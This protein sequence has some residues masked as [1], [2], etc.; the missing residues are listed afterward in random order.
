MVSS[1]TR[2]KAT[3][4]IMCGL[5]SAS[6]LGQAVPALAADGS[7]TI[8]QVAGN[9]GQKYVGYRLFSADV[10]T[11][12]ADDNTLPHTHYGKTYNGMHDDGQAI[13][14]D[15]PDDRSK[16][17]AFLMQSID[18]THATQSYSAWLTA[19][20]LDQT[21]GG[22]SPQNNPQN[23][24]Q[25]ISEMVDSTTA[26]PTADGTSTTPRTTS[27]S[28]FATALAQYLVAQGAVV[29]VASFNTGV[30][31]T[32][33]QGYYLFKTDPTSI[34][35]NEAGEAAMWVPISNVAKTITEKA[36]VPT[37]NKEVQEDATGAW[38]ATADANRAQEVSF[39]VTGTLPTNLAAFSD[40]FYEFEDQL[41]AGMSLANGDTSGVRVTHYR[42]A[43]DTTGTNVTNSFTRSYSGD[44]L[45]VTC[46]NILPIANVTKDSRFVVTYTAHLDNDGIIGGTGNTN[47]VHLNYTNDPITKA[48]GRT[49]D[50]DNTVY[51]YLLQFEKLDK[52]TREPIQGAKFTVRLTT[53]DGSNDTASVNKYLQADGSLGAT[54]YEFTTDASGRFSVPRIDKG[55][56]T[57]NETYAPEPYDKMD[58]PV[59]T[60]IGVTLPTAAKTNIGTVQ[61]SMSWS[62]GENGSQRGGATSVITSV[63]QDGIT[64]INGAAWGGDPANATFG[65]RI[66]DPKILMLPGTGLKASYAGVIAGGAVLTIGAIEITR[67]R[68]M[69]SQR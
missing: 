33:P 22:V 67:R 28:S 42:N 54:A 38:G 60:T 2:R 64:V 61:S 56:Y 5:M 6:V 66:S 51:T 35:N 7:I 8:N 26:S 10:T 47:S 17:V 53:A 45:T 18:Q 41:P 32:V 69:S 4:A 13:E 58:A 44:K 46:N 20:G 37:I 19:N 15:T 24:L 12:L 21:V 11:I 63:D 68:R 65:L 30:Q 52:Q 55:T 16:V 57:I 29:D 43:S 23:A 34:E 1:S 62:G 31:K 3:A 39:R 9:T 50:V 14:W 36:S 40:Y 48:H 25:Y 27:G 49:D 59:V